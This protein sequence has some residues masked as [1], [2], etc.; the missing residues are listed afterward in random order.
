MRRFIPGLSAGLLS[1]LALAGCGSAANNN[2][3]AAPAPAVAAPTVD[4]R[5]IDGLGATLVT[6]GG[7]TLYF[8][9]QDSAGQI[10]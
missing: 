3:A 9:D 7:A 1:A 4:V 2:S 6:A 10:H 8:A 5:N